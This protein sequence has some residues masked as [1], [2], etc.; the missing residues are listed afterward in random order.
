MNRRRLDRIA[1]EAPISQA[2]ARY[3]LGIALHAE[4]LR[5]VQ[6]TSED[7]GYVKQAEQ[8]FDERLAMEESGG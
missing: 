5:Q 3:L 4:V 1:E 8:L 2:D 6:K 7:P